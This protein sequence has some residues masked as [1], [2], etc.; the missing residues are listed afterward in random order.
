M[1]RTVVKFIS[2]KTGFNVQYN[3]NHVLINNWDED[4]FRELAKEELIDLLK[5]IENNPMNNIENSDKYTLYTVKKCKNK[6]NDELC[7]TSHGSDDGE[8][9]LCGIELN[10]N[11]FITQNEFDGIITCKKCKK[12]LKEYPTIPQRVK[13][14]Y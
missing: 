10:E 2:P 1:L 6:Y 7:K 3:A 8:K 9:T 11:W 12:V 4:N 13:N 5:Y 14:I